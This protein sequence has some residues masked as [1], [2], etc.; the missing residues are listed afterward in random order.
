M[1]SNNIDTTMELVPRST[2]FTQKPKEIE[3]VQEGQ[4]LC[5]KRDE[6]LALINDLEPGPY[7]HNPPIDDPKFDKLEPHSGIN[8]T[9][10]FASQFYLPLNL[11]LYSSRSISHEDFADYLRGRFYLSPSRL[12]STI[13]LLPDNQGYDVPVPGDWVTVAVVAERGPIKFTRAPAAIEA[14]DG[15]KKRKGKFESEK[16]SGKKY[17]NLKLIDFGARSLSTNGG[18]S[19]IRGDAFLTLLLFESDGFDLIPRG[20]G[21]K[22]EKLYKGGSRGAFEHLTNVKEGDVIA[23]LNPKILK[24]FQVCST[25]TFLL[26]SSA[27]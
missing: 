23:L 17:I 15:D 5:S 4:Y 13:R 3:P 6:R 14:E 11:I 21:M 9:S 2:G 16:S 1:N 18:T 10:V 26:C 22:P 27:Y 19:A 20:D 12:Y 8:L 7:E 24:P 25:N